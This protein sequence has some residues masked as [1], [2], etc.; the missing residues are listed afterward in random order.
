M[1]EFTVTVLGSSAAIAS[2]G[3]NLTSHLVDH[4]HNL[5]LIDCGEGTQFRLQHLKVKT[6]RIKNIFISHLHGDHFFGLIGFIS[7]MHLLHRTEELHIYGPPLL[8]KIIEL[9]LESTATALCYPL[10]FHSTQDDH[11]ELLYDDGRLTVHSFPLT[12]RVPTTG[13]IFREKQQPFHINRE[14]ID[15]Y[16]VPMI[17]FSALRDGKDFINDEGEVIP[18]HLLTHP[19]DNPRSYAYCS[20][21]I[22]KEDIISVIE[23][24]DLLYH[25]STFA[26]ALVETA[27]LKMHSTNV[28]AATLAD[29]AHAKRLML[30]H[31]SARYKDLL[32]MLD[33]AKAVFPETIIAIEGQVVP[34][35]APADTTSLKKA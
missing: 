17:Y 13:F 26:H 3:R 16:G 6:H 30:G 25:E 9:Q 4:N 32:L 1:K 34:I 23:G 11:E 19:A 27:G 18:N 12:H 15:K 21:T 28:Q 10:T 14:A 2:E 22:Y 20:D 8:K 33:E 35:L 31:F 5:F 7:T 29:K 24:C